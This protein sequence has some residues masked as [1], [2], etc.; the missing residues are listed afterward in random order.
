MGQLS[1][2]LFSENFKKWIEGIL[3]YE[4]EVGQNFSM[5]DIREYSINKGITKRKLSDD[6]WRWCIDLG[7]IEKLNGKYKTSLI[8]NKLANKI[9]FGDIKNIREYLLKSARENLI[10]MDK[11]IQILTKTDGLD[12]E[13]LRIETTKSM[14]KNETIKGLLEK[15]GRS[16]LSWEYPK[17]SWNNILNFLRRI[18]IIKIEKNTV[19]LVCSPLS[20]EDSMLLSDFWLNLKK[21]YK[22]LKSSN[23][24]IVGVDIIELKNLVCS[25]MSISSEEFIKKLEELNNNI[26]YVNNIRFV[27]GTLIKKDEVISIHDKLRGAKT[28]ISYIVVRE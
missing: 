10:V 1:V 22:V 17:K 19:F 20:S 5:K 14:R 11:T 8:L 18:D 4:T 24:D 27:R 23:Q 12:K 3:N 13:E 9:L 15:K 25:K 28:P 2:G 6:G 16:Y 26:N 7:L 21:Y